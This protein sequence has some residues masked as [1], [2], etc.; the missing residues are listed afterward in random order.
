MTA[1]IN[2]M[3]RAEITKR[4]G[5]PYQTDNEGV[6]E[7]VKKKLL[8]MKNLKCFLKSKYIVLDCSHRFCLHPWSN[9]LVLTSTGKT[10][11]HNCYD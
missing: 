2:E 3:L 8:T 1:L 5:K 11:C 9:T 4:N 7:S 10:H 6:P